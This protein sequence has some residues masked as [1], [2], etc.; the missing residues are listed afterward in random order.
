LLGGSF[1]IRHVGYCELL[2]E[3]IDW[4]Q[5]RDVRA[6]VGRKYEVLLMNNEISGNVDDRDILKLE[7]TLNCDHCIYRVR[8]GG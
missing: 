7:Q 3:S 2:Q 6:V 4:W 8:V 1:L 5:K